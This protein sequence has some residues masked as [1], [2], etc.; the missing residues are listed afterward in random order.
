M[1]A[2]GGAAALPQ[3]GG[4]LSLGELAQPKK[5]KVVLKNK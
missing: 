3:V 1:A 4:G 2:G 5:L